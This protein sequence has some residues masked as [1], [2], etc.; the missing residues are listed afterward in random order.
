MIDMLF[1]VLDEC[2]NTLGRGPAAPASSAL[3]ANWPLTALYDGEVDVITLFATN[4]ADQYAKQDANL[5][6]DPDAQ[7]AGW[8]D[9]SD[10]D[11]PGRQIEIVRIAPSQWFEIRA[12]QH[13]ES[14]SGFQATVIVQN[15]YNN[16][17]LAPNG[18]WS[19][20][21]VAAITATDPSEAMKTLAF[22]VEDVAACRGWRQV[23]LKVTVRDDA[24]V[25]FVSQITL[26]PAVNCAW[27]AGH[28]LGPVAPTVAWSEDDSSWIDV[29]VMTVEQPSFQASFAK[30]YARYWRVT[31]VGTNHE[32][33]YLCEMF[34]GYATLAMRAPRWGSKEEDVFPQTRHAND[35]GMVRVEPIAA[36]STRGLTLDFI[37]DDSDDRT[38]FERREAEQLRRELWRRSRAGTCAVFIIMNPDRPEI[39]IGTLSEKF[40]MT[41]ALDNYQEAGL[42]LEPLPICIVAP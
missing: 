40:G 32:A 17:Y 14:E 36:D 39:A 27:I 34:I 37:T 19:P 11:G 10:D 42:S 5:I 28:N 4:D 21:E 41:D 38:D 20:T 22:Q 15:P 7:T 29:A 26:I 3:D 12:M 30:T 13:Y 6:P 35:A 24:G 2:E 31:F 9:V 33:I 23:S 18:T 25:A 1:G 16:H 8:S